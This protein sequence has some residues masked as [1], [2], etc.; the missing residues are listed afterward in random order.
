VKIFIGIDDTDNLESRGTGFQA[1]MLGLSLAEAGLFEL[2]SIT[3]HQ[4]LVDSR[5]PYTSHNSSACL[6]GRSLSGI[7]RVIEH[8]RNFLIR[9]SAFDSDAGLCVCPSEDLPAGI[10]SFGVR[11]KREILSLEEAV[12]LA[13]RGGI[14]LEGFLN[15]RIGIIGS[16]AAVGL[17][18]AGDDGRLLWMKNLRESRGIFPASEYLNL[19]GI[20]IMKGVNGGQIPESAVLNITEWTRPV[21][22]GGSITLFLEKVE[23]HNEYEYQSA[24]KEFIKGIS[25]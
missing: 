23:N 25:E 11:A 20:E 2:H 17:R 21:M 14:Y 22:K 7:D 8:C 19:T 12:S 24:S 13:G 18:A 1:R 15:T 16:L 6:A 10:T 4:L 3:R 9:E 5:I